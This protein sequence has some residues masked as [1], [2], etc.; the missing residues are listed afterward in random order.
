MSVSRPCVLYARKSTDRED[1]QILSIPAQL[2]ELREYA[3]RSGLVI[4]RELTESCSA[5]KP[6]RTVFTSLLREAEAGR[7][8]RVLAWRLD[9]CARNPVDGG[10]LIY[11][12]GEN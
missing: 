8:E 2:R 1:K 12:L 11:L 10:Q 7:V 4:T 3:A 9:R 6:G 5:R